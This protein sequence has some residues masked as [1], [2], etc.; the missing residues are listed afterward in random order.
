M[1][2]DD[3][4]VLVLLAVLAEDVQ[5]TTERANQILELARSCSPPWDEEAQYEPEDPIP[6]SLKITKPFA[7][8]VSRL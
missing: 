3:G 8:G 1:N 7:F 2:D 4:R 6:T 5:V